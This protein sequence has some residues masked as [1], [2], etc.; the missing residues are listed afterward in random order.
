MA[1]T[2]IGAC[3][4]KYDS[5]GSLPPVYFD[6]A[7]A[8]TA[9]GAKLLPPYTVLKHLGTRADY[10]DGAG[11]VE[12]TDV[13]FHVYAPTLAAA[14]ETAWAVRFGGGDPADGAGFDRCL[15]LDM[16]RRRLAGGGCVRTGERMSRSA[17]VLDGGP[18]HLIEL[19]YRITTL[20][21]G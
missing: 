19:D 5:L 8:K 21:T 11:P 14:E 3:L 2:V 12:F 15:V 7:P 20:T 17:D 18:V 10:S 9:A 16:T 6:Q 13:S 1:N 4:A